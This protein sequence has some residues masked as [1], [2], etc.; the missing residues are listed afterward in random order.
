[1]RGITDAVPDRLYGPGVRARPSFHT[2][3]SERKG[4]PMANRSDEKKYTD[5]ELRERIKEEIKDS[6]KGGKKGQWSARK[7]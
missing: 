7:S 1:V 3:T 6:D 2:Q 4:Q 5:P